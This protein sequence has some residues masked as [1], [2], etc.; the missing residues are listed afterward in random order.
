MLQIFDEIQSR[1]QWFQHDRFGMFIHFGLYAIPARGEW[2][3]SAERLSSEQYRPFFEEFNPGKL[4]L[5]TWM[6][7]VKNAGMRY[8]VLTAKH[9]DGFCLFDSALTDYTSLN[10]PYGAD[11]VAEYVAAARC[12]GLRVGIYY[13]LV[14]WHHPAYGDR[15]HPHRDDETYRS[16]E[17]RFEVYLDYL[18]GQVRE[19]C[20]NYGTIDILW[21]DFSYWKMQGDA[22]RATELVEMVR[23]LQ[24]EVTIDNRLGGNMQAERP[25]PSAGDFAGP[26]QMIPRTPVANDAG[27]PLP[28]KHG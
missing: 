5:D 26:E 13:F 1:T 17:H 15:Q 20:S 4:D 10:T 14:D 25:E 3:R 24:P 6:R 7:V 28:R 11:I 16:V 19:L 27:L 18:Y 2:V 8:V 23:E 21:I 12:R 22:W 9:H